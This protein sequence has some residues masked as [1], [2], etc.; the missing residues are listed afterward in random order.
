MKIAGHH[1]LSMLTGNAQRIA[2]FYRATLGLRMVKKSVNQDDPSMY[3]LFFGDKAGSPGTELT[4]FELAHAAQTRRGSGAI[5]KISLLVRGKAALD[6]WNQRFEAMD[7]DHGEYTTY[8]GRQALPF[9][10]PDGLPL[11]LVDLGEGKTPAFWEEWADSPVPAEYRILGIG[12]VEFAVRKPE[13]TE[14]LLMR[15]FGFHHAF[16]NG[17]ERIYQSAEG[18]AFG[19]IV[20]KRSASEKERPGRGSVH[21]LAVRVSDEEELREWDRRIREQGL[22]TTGVVDRYYFQSLYFR[23]PNGILVE[24]ATDG[25]G[26]AADESPDA[27]GE[28]LALPPFLKERRAEIEAKLKPIR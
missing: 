26:F 24:L 10:D 12:P 7:V 11:Q 1:H 8:G 5:S 20:I 17:E 27:L 23:E 9:E 3:H 16:S 18:E 21:H 13:E 15:L 19:E 14:R 6:Y 28:R 4:F 22:H 25:P 2:D